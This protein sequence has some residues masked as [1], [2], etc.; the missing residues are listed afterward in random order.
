[1]F[2][3]RTPGV[4]WLIKG[5]ETTSRCCYSNIGYEMIIIIL[6][7]SVGVQSISITESQLPYIFALSENFQILFSFVS[8]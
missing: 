7:F 2:D 3:L 4:K 1:M 5:Q 6:L 8:V